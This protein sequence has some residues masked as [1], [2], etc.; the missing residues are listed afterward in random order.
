MPKPFQL[1]LRQGV[2]QMKR[3]KIDGAFLSPV[4][5]FAATDD[6]RGVGIEKGNI[7]TYREYVYKFKMPALFLRAERPVAFAAK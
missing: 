3:N 7:I 6:Q 5:E 4:R 1:G 2:R